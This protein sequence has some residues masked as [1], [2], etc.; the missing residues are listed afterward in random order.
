[1]DLFDAICR[2]DYSDA[3]SP[4]CSP[5]SALKPNSIMKRT[6]SSDSVEAPKRTSSFSKPVSVLKRVFSRK[7]SSST[8]VR[9]STAMILEYDSH[10]YCEESR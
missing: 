1:M 9:F 2:R 7:S 4:I 5:L 10:W 3:E 8:R 6:S